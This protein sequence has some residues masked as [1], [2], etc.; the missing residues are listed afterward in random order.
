[1]LIE[2]PEEIWA[3]KEEEATSRR[4]GL[5]KD[6][7]NVK[8]ERESRKAFVKRC[9]ELRVDGTLGVS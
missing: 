6:T 1:M 8:K 5:R 4:C 7:V 9:P 3:R 2:I